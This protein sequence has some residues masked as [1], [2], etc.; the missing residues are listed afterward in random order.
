MGFFKLIRE[1]KF[2]SELKTNWISS[3]HKWLRKLGFLFIQVIQSL[4]QIEC[5]LDSRVAEVMWSKLI[6]TQR[7]THTTSTQRLKRQIYKN[8]SLETSNTS[9][10]LFTNCELHAVGNLQQDQKMDPTQKVNPSDPPA[11][12]TEPD[13][14]LTRERHPQDAERRWIT[15]ESNHQTTWPSTCSRVLFSKFSLFIL[16]I[17]NLLIVSAILHFKP[18]S[19]ESESSQ[20]P[21]L[22]EFIDYLPILHDKE[23]NQLPLH[24]SSLTQTFY[25]GLDP[26]LIRSVESRWRPKRSI[27]RQIFI[28]VLIVA[29]SRMVAFHGTNL[30]SYVLALM[31]S[32]S[33]PLPVWKLIKSHWEAE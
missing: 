12:L 2:F 1:E 13:D 30:Q 16:L 8:T 17:S 33:N 31:S 29:D 5:V 25:P 6:S 26:N 10:H 3:P 7:L 23:G 28:E 14:V 4:S 21:P 32:V 9:H 24:N 22:V 11:D 15:T 27:S 20:E 18:K 19:S